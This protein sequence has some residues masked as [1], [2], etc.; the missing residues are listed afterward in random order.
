MEGRI[1]QRIRQF[2]D[3]QQRVG[4][5]YIP[6]KGT[7]VR[8]WAPFATKAEIDWPDGRHALKAGEDGYFS[9][10][11]PEAMPGDPYTFILD[12]DIWIADPASRSQPEGIA[13]PSAVVAQDYSW[14]ADDWQGV[15]FEEWVIYELHTGTFSGRG[16]FEGIVED[17]PRLKKLGVSVLEI[18]PVAQFSGKR[19]WGYDGV[20]PFAVQNSY[21]GP[22]K[23]KALVDACHREGLA[24]ILDCVYN[25][26]GPEGNIL[27][28]CGPYV[29]DKYKT[30]W[31]DALNF[32]GPHSEEVR[33]YFLQN[34]WQWLTEYRFDG[35]RLDAVQTIFDTS[36]VPFLEELSLLKKAAEKEVGRPLVL[37]A[38]TD[39]NDARLL[40]PSAQGGMGME[41]HWNDDLHH[42]LHAYLTGEDQ[43]YFSDYGDLEQIVRCYRDGNCFQGN[44]SPFRKRR[45]G[46]SY[47]GVDRK[48]LVVE[49]QNHDQTGNR[50]LGQ[51]LISLTDFEKAK[52]AAA[53]ILLSPF[54]PLLFMGEEWGEDSPFLYFIDHSDP[55]LVK[56]VQDGR[57]REFS[58]FL[59]QGEPPDPVDQG[60][61]D[62]CVLKAKSFPEDSQEA[63]MGTYYGMLIDL[64][65]KLR[66]DEC[67][68]VGGYD[69]EYDSENKLIAL[70]TA[71]QEE[72]FLIIFSF[73]DKKV[74]YTDT[75]DRSRMWQ[76][77]LQSD[78]FQAGED[79]SS[80]ESEETNELTLAPFSATVLRG[81]RN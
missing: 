81:T 67:F 53:C 57:K 24:I 1:A 40:V 68:P 2:T 49:S 15:P 21:G 60:T 58:D 25:H 5:T 31:G 27:Y 70:R 46:R 50:M 9:G 51:R 17:L 72:Y 3:P 29:Q 28:R 20:F 13:G 76:V 16:D 35:L 19:N 8:L 71:G 63:A 44:Y 6:G 38:E 79:Y 61:F 32:D 18:M 80:G 30:P 39:M 48:R 55:A 65:K 73:H 64:S 23:L 75:E 62:K 37:I 26:L 47:E 45:H 14:G 34:A 33:R 10:F 78:R 66:R 52:L 7:A 11:F 36:P 69:V 4:T 22:E 41:A 74:A 77:V 59:W 42:S 54:T 43:G 12:G 56:A